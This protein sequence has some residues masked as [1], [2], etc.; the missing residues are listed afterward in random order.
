MVD[1]NACA[2]LKLELGNSLGIGAHVIKHLTNRTPVMGNPVRDLGH[3]VFATSV[4]YYWG[5]RFKFLID[6]ADYNHGRFSG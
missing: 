3:P 5:I 2:T 4:S 1:L 6:P